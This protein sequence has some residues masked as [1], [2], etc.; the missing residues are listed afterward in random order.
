MKN[1]NFLSFQYEELDW[2]KQ[3]EAKI[4]V[5]INRYI[6][7]EIILRKKSKSI[8]LFDMGFGVGFFIKMFYKKVQ[9]IYDRIIIEGC[10]PSEKSFSKFKKSEVEIKNGHYLNLNK[11]FFLDLKIED[12]KFDVLTSIYIFNCLKFGELEKTFEKIANILKSGGLF[13]LVVSS[14][15]CFLERVRKDKSLIIKKDI[16][17]FGGSKYKEITHYTDLEG[18]GR[19]V[20][21]NRETSLYIDL[22]KK[23]NLS[24]LEKKEVFDNDLISSVL[25]FEK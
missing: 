15:N 9:D 4:N 6:I 5:N 8:N 24:L 21:C 19:I 20:D 1:D 2:F 18:L 23:Y 16:L 17:E 7:E 11:S 13:F 22:A 14:D 10:E 12:D 3:E 25:I